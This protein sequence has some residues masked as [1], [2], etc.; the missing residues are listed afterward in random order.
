MDAHYWSDADLARTVSLSAAI[1]SAQTVL[2]HEAAANAWNLNKTMATW[3]PASSAHSL[4]AVDIADG[5]VAFKNWIN[6]PSGAAALMTVFSA[7]DGAL[8]AVAQA[9]AAGVLRTAA[10]SAVATRWLA[11]P[12]AD[13][14]AILG[15]GRQARMQAAAVVA[16]RPIRRVRVWSRT[17][18]R[19]AA[20]ARQLGEE[21]GLE[22]LECE[23]SAEAT[24]DAAVVTLITRAT[25]PFLRLSDLAEGAH[26]NAVGAILPANAEFTADV[27]GGAALIAV[28][29]LANARSGSRELREHFGADHNADWSAVI[30]LAEVVT[31]KVTRPP[32]PRCTV[33]KGMGMGLSDLAVARLL[34]RAKK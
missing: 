9:G 17:P 13:E 5:V 27:L 32:R 23:H 26:L 18:D 33:F 7:A 20:F 21:L 3:P 31:G 11:D 8:L 16:V 12:A 28:D 15:T 6:T 14:L 2:E 19:R 24:R 4:G 22:V 29:S 1:D 10:M 25:E 34:V 30:A